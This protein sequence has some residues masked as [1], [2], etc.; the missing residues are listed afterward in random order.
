MEIHNIYYVIGSIVSKFKIGITMSLYCKVNAKNL[1]QT[2][3]TI[4]YPVLMV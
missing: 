3:K 1:S 2:C 4:T